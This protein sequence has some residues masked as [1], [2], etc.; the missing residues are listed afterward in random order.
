M[1]VLNKYPIFEPDQVLT[2]E[3][4]NNLLTYLD[5]QNRLSRTQL[6]GMGIVCGLE[7][8]K[9]TKN[10]IHISRGCGVSSEGYL[11]S[12][13]ACTLTQF[14][15]YTAPFPP[16]YDLFYTGE[17][18]DTQI[19]LW[20]LKPAEAEST[21]DVPLF[22]LTQAFLADKAVVLYLECPEISLKN[23]VETDCDN[24]GKELVF[25]LRKLL[26]EKGQLLSIIQ[27]ANSEGNE[28][29]L[30]EAELA[31]TL[32]GQYN[33]PDVSLRRFSVPISD[34]S[35][36]EKLLTQ[37]EN[38]IHLAIPQ[39]AS[40]LS[41]SYTAF[42]PVISD[43]FNDTNPFVDLENQLNSSFSTLLAENAINI[44][45]FYD[46]LSDLIQAYDEFRKK[47]FEL[48]SECC[49][50]T[51]PF[52]KHLMLGEAEAGETDLSVYRNYFILAP[53]YANQTDL[54]AEIRMLYRRLSLL[55]ERL[56]IPTAGQTIRIT[57]SSIGKVDLSEK[58][59]PFY[60]AIGADATHPLHRF[61]NYDKTR[62]GKANR[63]LS[64]SA[65]T[66]SSSDAIL[67]PLNYDIESYDFFRVEGHIGRPYDSVLKN[68][69]ETKR[70]YRL[71]FDI[72]A[73]KLGDEASDT[74]IDYS[75]HFEDLEALYQ[76]IRAD[77]FC[78][79]ELVLC[80]FSEIPFDIPE[81]P[82]GL[83]LGNLASFVSARSNESAFSQ[84][85]DNIAA[86][87]DLRVA[88]R[89][90]IA[91]YQKGDFLN[92]V[93]EVA[94]NTL[95]AAYNAII[96]DPAFDNVPFNTALT[97]FFG[98]SNDSRRLVLMYVTFIMNEIDEVVAAIQSETFR[99]LDLEKF[100]EEFEQMQAIVKVISEFLQTSDLDI[101]SGNRSF[102][103]ELVPFF[104]KLICDCSLAEL[105]ALNTS[106]EARRTDVLEQN[107]FSNFIEQHPGIEHKAGVPKGGTLVLVYYR[108]LQEEQE[109]PGR[110]IVTPA[111]NNVLSSNPFTATFSVQ[112]TI[113]SI[114]N[115]LVNQGL[116][117]NTNALTELLNAA[118][119]TVGEEG[120]SIT[121]KAVIADFYLPYV[122]CSDCPPISYV[123]PRP[124]P[125]ISL[126]NASYCKPDTSENL[127]QFAVSPAGGTVSGPGVVNNEGQ[128]FFDPNAEEVEIGEVIFTYELDGET[129][130]LL[131][132][133]VPAPTAAFSIRELPPP[134]THAAVLFGFTNESENAIRVSWDF[135]DG[136]D[137]VVLTTED[138]NFE[139]IV[140]EYPSGLP[141]APYSVVL[142]AFNGN[143]S[144]SQTQTIE[145]L[146]PEEIVFTVKEEVFTFCFDD[147]NQYGLSVS[148]AGGTIS[149]ENLI[150]NHP[151]A[152]PQFIPANVGAGTHVLTYTTAEG[153]TA[154]LSLEVVQPD[155][156]FVVILETDANN[157]ET[158]VFT[159]N[160][161]GGSIHN[162]QF[163][164]PF[165]GNLQSFGDR[166]EKVSLPASFFLEFQ[167]NELTF[168]HRI[169]TTLNDNECANSEEALVNLE[170]LQ[171]GGR[172]FTL[173]EV[174]GDLNKDL[175]E[176]EV[177]PD[178]PFF[179]R[180]LSPT[181][182]VYAG[183]V[184]L[185]Q[186]FANDLSDRSIQKDYLEGN[187]NARIAEGTDGQSQITVDR[188]LS[189]PRNTPLQS[190]T[191]VLGLFLIQ[192]KQ[193]F[194]LSMIQNNQLRGNDPIVRL[195]RNQI[196]DNFSK[197]KNNGIDPD[198]D[199][200]ISSFFDAV[201]SAD[202]QPLMAEQAK[203]IQEVL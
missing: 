46:F 174:I 85:S 105:Q 154:I 72:I 146:P 195:L 156:S 198:P 115:M 76:Q 126:P 86:R 38:L 7:L 189:L 73:L 161:N 185:F 179:S 139:R 4:L 191:I 95:G 101:I 18:N 48:V 65:S 107:L 183:T 53:I 163:I 165:D 157:N 138:E 108:E 201:I 203:R 82:G 54:L 99:A 190:K 162:W 70:R 120:V 43:L 202:T 114:Q 24:K 152:G 128:F 135:G 25:T 87:L 172:G 21:D 12:S 74:D 31:E 89:T 61:W 57:P 132:E 94:D 35:D 10:S 164:N 155:A 147:Q 52:P 200:E 150:F 37:Y 182:A 40:A 197:I 14:A 9:P 67:Q 75:C 64:Y 78:N 124:L 32:F 90:L 28:G 180:V 84:L 93:C 47:A 49:P 186:S 59:I 3:H 42:A 36:A 77:L 11:I 102:I 2:S 39:V 45:Y 125:T 62:K 196:T 91:Q 171:G 176:L 187:A 71:P 113:T 127:P 15:D 96:N 140:H 142:T 50:N 23:C 181:D 173:E 134:V 121:D 137:V 56:A 175:A 169:T 144:D 177:L 148:P 199:G 129:A 109:A 122:C 106:Y 119:L 26:I 29:E 88:A 100:T 111:R 160:Q 27:Q 151:T 16:R 116:S 153:D 166:S 168:I 63:N 68:L 192:V 8:S 170:E 141:E 104:D 60:Y 20:E 66:Y 167:T 131:I 98:N 22:P 133:V 193:L 149:P 17:D 130:E 44:Q 13:E 92:E 33:L 118:L 6:I 83:V 145:A 136:S 112:N 159:A 143:C 123:F 80:E 178:D 81:T 110:A 34:V 158:L 188:L 117:V 194:N 55:V 51:D 184:G 5:Q 1:E 79:L 19:P 103:N 58:A 97:S 30:T 69:E 41:E